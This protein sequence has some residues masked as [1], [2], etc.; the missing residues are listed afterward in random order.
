LKSLNI[1]GYLF[2]LFRYKKPNQTPLTKK[3]N[4]EKFRCLIDS[5]VRLN[6]STRPPSFSRR[7]IESRRTFVQEGNGQIE[8]CTPTCRWY[9]DEPTT[10][11]WW[12]RTLHLGETRGVLVLQPTAA[13]HRRQFSSRLARITVTRTSHGFPDG[14][15]SGKCG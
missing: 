6:I 10:W 9:F 14:S 3:K 15:G 1:V 5:D 7:C 2:R 13:V 11:C 12:C 8:S 4:R